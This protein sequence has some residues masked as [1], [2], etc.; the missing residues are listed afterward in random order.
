VQVAVCGPRECTDAERADAHRVGVLLAEAGAT[1][2]CGGGSGVMAAVAAGVRSVG[3]LV[4]GV[5]PGPDAADANPDLSAVIVTNLGEARNAVIVWS[6]DAVI[7]VGCSW[8]TLSEIALARWRGD[9]PVVTLG[10]WRVTRADG[11]ALPDAPRPAAT[12]EE[13]VALALGG[14]P[15]G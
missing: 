12:P 9:V 15:A 8:G 4:I 6:A 13:A 3:G 5:R 7:A 11:T 2:V 1:V 10:G 14:S